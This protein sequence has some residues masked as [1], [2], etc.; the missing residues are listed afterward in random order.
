MRQRCSE[1]ALVARPSRQRNKRLQQRAPRRF[2]A[3][4]ASLA[5]FGGRLFLVTLGFGVS[6]F[7][8]RL[9]IL[10][11]ARCRE[12]AD[13]HLL[14]RLLAKLHRLRGIRVERIAG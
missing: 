14:P 12:E 3:M 4:V 8:S 9:G 1:G 13:Q 7:V 10:F 5:W 2:L 6:V 11:R